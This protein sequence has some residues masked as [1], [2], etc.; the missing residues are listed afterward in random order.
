M[1]DQQQN[2]PKL[3]HSAVEVLTML[4]QIDARLTFLQAM[5]NPLMRNATTETKAL[6]VIGLD[7]AKRQWAPKFSVPPE[8]GAILQSGVD[9]FAAFHIGELNQDPA[10]K[11]LVQAVYGATADSGGLPQDERRARLRVVGDEGLLAT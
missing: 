2:V 6:A 1:S 3:Q 5:V 8:A 7:M 9:A 11:A 4:N 10:V